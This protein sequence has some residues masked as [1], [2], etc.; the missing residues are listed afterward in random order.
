MT[1]TTLFWPFTV[2]RPKREELSIELALQLIN[3]KPN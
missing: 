2:K 3:F 1:E